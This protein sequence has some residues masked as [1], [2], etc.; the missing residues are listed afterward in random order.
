MVSGKYSALSGAI[1]MEQNMANISNNLANVN[2]TGFKKDQMSFEAILRGA[3]Q[4][5][6]AK[7]INYTRVNRNGTDFSEGPIRV[8]DNPLDLAIDGEGFF[9]VSNGNEVFFTRQGSFSLDE[10]GKLIT[11][12]GYSLLDDGNQPVQLNGTAG[13]LITIDED[14]YITINGG[15]EG[16]VQVFTVDDPTKLKKSANT[17]FQLG[18]GGVD[19]PLQDARIIQGSLE[20]SNV[21]IMEEM[22]KM[23]ET[24]RKYEAYHKVLKSYQTLSEKQ[25]E[26]GTVG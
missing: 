26:L 15:Q 24:H 16:K 25:D 22:A 4:I 20:Y 13:Q 6:N 10:S 9:K 12:S 18:E 17:L 2:T 14:G 11:P 1:A 21:N 7:G 19:R 5:Q 23:I 3:Q 8:T